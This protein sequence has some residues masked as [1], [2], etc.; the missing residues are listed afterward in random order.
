METGYLLGYLYKTAPS[1]QFFASTFA[2]RLLT[3]STESTSF[4]LKFPADPEA[5][6][7]PMSK[8][9]QDQQNTDLM[10]KTA[11]PTC[12]FVRNNT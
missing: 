1:A 9:S 8:P 7:T 12:R 10:S 6:H 3:P 2:M 11:Q 5:G 4:P